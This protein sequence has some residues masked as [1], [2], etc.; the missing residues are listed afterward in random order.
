[1]LE[2]HG[3]EYGLRLF[4]SGVYGGF[5]AVCLARDGCKRVGCVLG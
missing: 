1:M 2:G 3:R 5:L 4:V